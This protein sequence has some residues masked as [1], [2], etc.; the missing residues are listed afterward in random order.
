MNIFFL[1]VVVLLDVTALTCMKLS[2]G[3]TRIGPVFIVALCY[4]LELLCQSL[5]LRH[6]QL[7]TAYAIW[8]SAGTA[9]STVVGIMWFRERATA[10]KMTSLGLVVLGVIGLNLSGL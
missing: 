2:W 3:F 9:L 6:F 4:G 1:I 7:S 5:A 10:W 8:G